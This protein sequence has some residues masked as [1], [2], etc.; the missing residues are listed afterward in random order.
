MFARAPSL[1]FWLLVAMIASAV[2][3]LGAAVLL[4]THVQNSNE[5]LVDTAMARHQAQTIA[6]EVRAGARPGR[7]AALQALLPSDQIT[8]ERDGR[9][10]FQGRRPAGNQLE[11][12]AAA[13]FPG[14]VVTLADYASLGPNSTLDLVV[15]I[16][17]VLALVIVAAIVAATLVARAVRAPVQ[18]AIDAAERVSRGDFAARMGSSGPE[19]LV[20]LGGAFDDMAARLER[21]DQDQRQFL[22]DVAHEIATPVNAVSGFA[23]ALADGAAAD[24][25][26]RREAKIVIDAETA[27]LRTLLGDLR[28]LT[29]LDLVTG[30]HVRPL[31]LVPFAERLVA[32]F[33]PSAREA[34]L[35]LRLEVDDAEALTDRRLL[36]MIAT[37]LITNAIR[38]TPAGGSVQVG[39]RRHG[40][41]LVLSVSDTGVGI[42]P[43]HQRRIFER[44]Y[45]VDSTR[46]RATGGS[47]LG[48]AIV[49]RAVDA[50]DGRI[51]LQSTPGAGSRF[52]VTVPADREAVSQAELG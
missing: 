42:A 50:L 11:L 16:A 26:A 32:S 9:V 12:K 30:S 34:G 49:R 15:I 14:G 36:E 37:N 10:I 6:G 25:P 44:L 29:Q 27:R 1:R 7:L 13:P 41:E 23:V 39:L 5:R 20:K 45:R 28:E 35:D 18:R 46:D 43:E 52:R 21:A 2:V 40:D 8:V 24:E 4:F 31:V 19:E 38:Y 33:R 22:A 3:G 51:E 48:L 47:G 17:G